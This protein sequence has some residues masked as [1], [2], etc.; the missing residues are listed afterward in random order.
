MDNKL[1]VIG[2]VECRYYASDIATLSHAGKRPRMFQHL[3][4]LS[5]V[6]G[7]QKRNDTLI[8]DYSIAVNA[9]SLLKFS[10][11]KSKTLL[12]IQLSYQLCKSF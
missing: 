2:G 5:K 7:L 10:L 12:I 6:V 9:T 8:N 4:S 11:L 3:M 1:S